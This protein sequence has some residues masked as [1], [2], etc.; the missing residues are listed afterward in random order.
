MLLYN[1]HTSV[2]ARR[3]VEVYVFILSYHLSPTRRIFTFLYQYACIVMNA[4]V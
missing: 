1:F 2:S 3:I 4:Q